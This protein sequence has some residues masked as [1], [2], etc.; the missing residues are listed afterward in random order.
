MKSLDQLTAA[1]VMTRSLISARPDQDLAEIERVMVEKRITGLP[2]IERGRLVGVISRSDIARVEVLMQ[3]LDSQ[4]T[5]E[6]HSEATQADGFQHLARPEYEGFRGKLDKLKVRDA[7]RDQAITCTPQTAVS[8]IAAMMIDQHIHRVI[9]V[10]GGDQPVGIVSSLDLVRL[11]AP[12][13]GKGLTEP[14]ALP[15]KTQA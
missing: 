15:K 9:V 4:V 10:D 1:D 12:E 3:S 6:L 14:S 5:H 8:E 11:L 7:M 2:V 13:R